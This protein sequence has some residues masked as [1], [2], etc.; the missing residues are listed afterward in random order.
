MTK[1]EVN[2]VFFRSAR[3]ASVR[4]YDLLKTGSSHSRV[5]AR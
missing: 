1:Y 4:A 2:L 5:D 3:A